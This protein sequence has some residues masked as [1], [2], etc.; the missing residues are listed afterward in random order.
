VSSLKST[1]RGFVE[2]AS[3]TIKFV[4]E[5]QKAVVNRTVHANE[6]IADLKVLLAEELKT[7]R[8][9][10]ILKGSDNTPL[11]DSSSI[12]QD[13]DVVA[14]EIVKSSHAALLSEALH[15]DEVIK[16]RTNTQIEVKIADG[17]E[18]K[19]RTIKVNVTFKIAEKVFL[20]GFR[21]SRNGALYH[22]AASQTAPKSRGTEN[23]RFHRDTQTYD[24]TSKS[25]N[26]T[27]ECGTQ[28]AR[29]DL[30]IKDDS[31][32]VLPR[33][34]FDSDQLMLVKQRDALTIQCAV[35]QWFARRDARGRLKLKLKKK[36]I[37]EDK[38]K[39]LESEA[40]EVEE[41]NCRSN[42]RTTADFQKLME[43]VEN[44]V[45]SETTRIKA[46]A[47]TPEE[48]QQMLNDLL[49]KE[50]KLIQTIER[51]KIDAHKENTQQRIMNTLKQMAAPKKWRVSDN[52][53]V[54]TETPWTERA[55]QLMILYEGLRLR[56]IRVE[57]RQEI[58][59]SVR[60]L[61]TQFSFPESRELEAL[62]VRE[63]DMMSRRRPA[64]SLSGLRQ[65]METLFLEII[66]KPE[67]NPEAINYRLILK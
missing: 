39:G 3:R 19:I 54:I 8:S 25:C 15:I 5:Q 66:E 43:Q 22:H 28:M 34:Y 56:S 63:I 16:P 37:V 30:A 36:Q 1:T 44:W 50:T 58:L 41:M 38:K 2:M 48:K 47:K 20:G 55:A 11:N 9:M 32:E 35:R 40:R 27:R 31:R 12:P 6:K 33:P 13:L 57:D 23:Q 24:V 14:I 46:I 29:K 26:T 60:D 52:K 18:G 59:I 64:A 10:L 67:V 62:L 42:P 65:R 53:M 17:P 51:L 7:D 49:K 4:A 21:D 61:I 45:A